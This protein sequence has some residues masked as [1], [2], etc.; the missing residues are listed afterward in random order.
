MAEARDKHPEFCIPMTMV[1]ATISNNVPGT[2][3]TLG[4]DTALNAICDVSGLKSFVCHMSYSAVIANRANVSPTQMFCLSLFFA[5]LAEHVT[6]HFFGRI[7]Q[8]ADN[9][10]AHQ[11]LRYQ[12]DAYFVC[13]PP[14]YPLPPLSRLSKHWH[15]HLGNRWLDQRCEDC[16]CPVSKNGDKQ[17]VVDKVWCWSD[18]MALAG[19][20]DL[21]MMIAN[22]C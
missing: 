10:P 13:S 9:V 2:D 3:F 8:V 7:M 22:R 21:M 16:S 14:L 5:N 6:C 19:F 18:A 15:A 1:P 20:D 12:G 11:A 4:T 17:C